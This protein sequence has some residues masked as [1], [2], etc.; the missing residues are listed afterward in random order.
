MYEI[1][2]ISGH[3]TIEMGGFRA[4]NLHIILEVIAR[5]SAGFPKDS[6]IDRDNVECRKDAI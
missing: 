5:Q 1:V 3:D 6:R 4:C 2:G